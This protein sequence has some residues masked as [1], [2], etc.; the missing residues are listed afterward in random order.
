MIS[1]S[2]LWYYNNVAARIVYD[3]RRNI[4][5]MHPDCVP[6]G[7]QDEDI[8]IDFAGECSA[9]TCDVCGQFIDE[10]AAYQDENDGESND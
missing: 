9:D 4:S 5:V 10:E 7:M 6:E 3:E 8:K 2:Q 1:S